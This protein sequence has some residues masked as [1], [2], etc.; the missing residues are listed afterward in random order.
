MSISC[1]FYAG[2]LNRIPAAYCRLQ[3]RRAVAKLRVVVRPFDL[4]DISLIRRLSERGVWLHTV[5]ALAENVHPL[6]G[7]LVS[8]LV[9]GEFSTYVW[10]P[11][12]G[13]RPGFIQMRVANGGNQANLLYLSPRYSD[14]G[15]AGHTLA[16]PDLKNQDSLLWLALLDEA[17]AG[18]GSRGI[19]HVIAE[20]DERSPEIHILRRAGFAVYTRQDIWA[21]KAADYRP[22]GLAARQLERRCPNDDW[23]IQLLYANTVP[24]LVQLVE[25]GPSVDN[26]DGWVWRHD[27]ELAAFVSIHHGATATWL[28]LFIHPDAETEADEIV[29]SAL[30]VSFAAEPKVV[31]C[32]V[33]R[34]ESWLPSALERSGF[35]VCGS[36][37]VMVRH[38]VHHASR[39]IPE[40]AI[41]LEPQRLTASS[42]LVRHFRKT[43]KNGR[44]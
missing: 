34:Y 36:Q 33:R 13:G 35:T 11:E 12:N 9:G 19:H 8:M 1:T 32:C 24:R 27:G 28:R 42:P 38:T 20:L 6:R 18:A 39:A 17:V 37:A 15:A 21:V 22:Q 40:G 16:G 14:L 4:R 3:R 7:A 26:G 25:P 29:A 44:H 41:S 30:E 2:Y 10:K 43:Q 5:S 23:D 31:Y